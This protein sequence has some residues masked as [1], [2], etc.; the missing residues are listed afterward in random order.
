M[1]REIGL[2]LCSGGLLRLRSIEGQL[3]IL[4]DSPSR[5]VNRTQSGYPSYVPQTNELSHGSKNKGGPIR[6]QGEDRNGRRAG[7]SR[8]SESEKSSSNPKNLNG[9]SACDRKPDENFAGCRPCLIHIKSRSV[10]GVQAQIR[11]QW[12]QGNTCVASS[13]QRSDIDCGVLPSNG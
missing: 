4:P 7:G 8:G 9:S 5:R 2:V 3:A 12:A 13:K 11:R 1:A 6:D 10:F